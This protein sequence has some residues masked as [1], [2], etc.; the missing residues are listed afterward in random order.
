V[1]GK[2][3]ISCNLFRIIFKTNGGREELKQTL[4]GMDEVE[5]LAKDH[6]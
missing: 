3:N 4:F 5:K 2:S 1:N 6:G